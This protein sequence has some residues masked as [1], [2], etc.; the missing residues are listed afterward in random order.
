MLNHCLSV[1]SIAPFL[2]SVLNHYLSVYNQDC[3][4]FNFQFDIFSLFDFILFLFWYKQMKVLSSTML[5][6]ARSS[7]I[8]D[9]RCVDWVWKQ[10]R[11]TFEIQLICW[12]SSY[13]MSDCLHV[14]S[15]YHHLNL[16]KCHAT[17]LAQCLCKYHQKI[18]LNTFS[19]QK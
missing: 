10:L 1:L 13:H 16:G 15:P 6:V 5:G 19:C 9:V 4:I 3:F 18:R 12:L 11:S 17:H 8:L 7:Q 2:L 14:M